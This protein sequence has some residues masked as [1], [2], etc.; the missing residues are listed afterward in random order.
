MPPR[1]SVIV[2]TFNRLQFLIPALRSLQAQT[3]QDFELIIADDGSDGAT[4]EYLQRLAEP[5]RV[6]VLWLAHSGRPAIV[7]NA[8]LQVAR[9]QYV[10]FLDSDDLWHPEKLATQL[11]SLER[12][13]L[14]Q[15]SCTA[16]ALVDASGCPISSRAPA[17]VA[18]GWIAERMLNAE[19]IIALPSVL[20]A[21][22]LL[23]QLGGFDETL[24]MCE[25]DELWLRLSTA[26]EIDAIDAP[27]TLVRRHDCHG[28]DDATAWYDRRRVFEKALRSSGDTRLRP[29]LHRLRAETAAGL[30][31]SLASAGRTLAALASLAASAAYSW[32]YGSWWRRVPRTLLL[33][34]APSA[35][36]RRRR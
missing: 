28:G 1:V 8:A 10:A 23:E 12:H 3:F 27:L 6:Q 25:D 9:G 17:R 33:A 20:V 16:F 18:S 5:P 2:P 22:T 24:V 30:A 29:L 19:L 11:T 36:A 26:S 31:R 13:P 35:H 4:R 14:R 32:R 7:R 15:W 34:L 21:R